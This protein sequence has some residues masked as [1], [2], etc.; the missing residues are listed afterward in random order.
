MDHINLTRKSIII[1][2]KS[3]RVGA[4][5]YLKG[6]SIFTIVLMHLINL[7]S[8]LPSKIQTLASF[9]GAGVHVFFLCSGIGLYLSYLRKKTTYGEFFKRRFTKVYIPYIIIVFI[10]FFLPWMYEGSERFLA[11]LSHILL[12]KMFIPHFEVSFGLQLWFISTI[13]QFYFLFLPMCKI[14]SKI[15]NN[16]IFLGLFFAISVSWWI[17]CF[18]TGIQN[19]RIWSSFC[20][21]YIW[22]FALGFVIAE[23]IFNGK[24][25]KINNFLL[26]MIAIIGTSVQAGMAL[27]SDMLRV[28][29]D[30]PSLCGYTSLALLF[31]NIS[32]VNKIFIWLSKISYEYYLVHILIFVTVFHFIKPEG[33]F[34]QC[35]IGTFSM[36]LALAVA[37]FYHRFLY[38]VIFKNKK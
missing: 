10:S 32:W 11:L 9:G 4:I 35:V 33:I 27:S 25:Y 20:L 29:N 13:I 30:I 36:I 14:K 16:T 3:N 15:K 5:D 1:Q 12:F 17:F 21:Q 6:F 2:M 26:F 19:T 18:C 37:F 7:L 23:Q 22:E 31:I 38:S 24:I 8:A 28:F 34:L